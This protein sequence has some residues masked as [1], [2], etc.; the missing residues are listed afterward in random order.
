G[1]DAREA[2]NLGLEEQPVGP[3]LDPNAHRPPPSVDDDVNDLVVGNR[4]DG[5]DIREVPPA[6]RAG[7]AAELLGSDGRSI[8]PEHHVPARGH[9]IVSGRPRFRPRIDRWIALVPSPISSTF[10][11]R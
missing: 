6:G 8:V 11:S 10:A 2:T 4:F 1:A 9:Q 5:L 3:A 7:G